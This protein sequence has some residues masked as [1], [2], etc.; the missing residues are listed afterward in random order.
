MRSL[1]AI[2]LR[3]LRR[4]KGRYVLTGL[5]IALG[6]A[7]AFAVLVTSRATNEA[8]DRVTSGFVGD[9]DVVL[10]PPGTFD[11][12]F[13]E[14]T[15]DDV[16]RIPG[17]ADAMGVHA[18]PTAT[19][20]PDADHPDASLTF[21]V[22]GLDLDEARRI[23]DFDLVDGRFFRRER[24][25]VV[26]PETFADAVEIDV[27]A[28]LELSF[29]AGLRPVRV[30]GII[31]DDGAGLNNGGRVAY[32]SLGASRDLAG[33]LDV[34]SSIDVVLEPGVDVD[35]WMEEARR[36]SGDRFLVVKASELASTFRD[37]LAGVQSALG[38]TAVLA[39][40][41]GGFLIFLTFS[42]SVAERTRMY[43]TLRALGSLPAQVSRIVVGEAAAL[44][45][46]GGV[47]G[48]GIGYVLAL[49]SLGFVARLVD[50]PLSGLGFRVGE[51]LIS[52]A[53]GLA[54][55]VG[56]SLVPAR[57]ASSLSPVA[58]MGDEVRVEERVS[59][60]AAR[61]TVFLAG[62]ALVVFGAGLALQAL[63]MLLVLLGAVLLVPV[64]VRP[65]ARGLGAVTARVGRGVGDIAVMHLV[66]ERSRSAYTLALVMVV[67]AATLAIGGLNLSMSETLDEVVD[68]Q[69]GADLRVQAA[70][71]F[72]P[73]VGGELAQIQGVRTASP[74]RF[75]TTEV[76]DG[77]DAR[78]TFVLVIDPTTYF[79]V[80]NFPWVDGD[81]QSARRALARG[82]SV[83]VGDPLARQLGVEV[84]EEVTVRTF[85]G[86]RKLRVAGT[87]AVLG[88]NNG[89]AVSAQDAEALLGAG[90]PMT[91]FIRLAPG[92]GADRA[93]E[94]IQQRLGDR[95][96]LIIE[97]AADVKAFAQSQLSGFFGI[98][99]AIVLVTAI[100]G[101]LGLANTLVV[102]VLAR[103]RE[104]GILRSTGVL[105]RQLWAMVL[106]EAATLVLCAF[107]LSLPLGG[108]LGWVSVRVGAQSLGFTVGYLTPWLLVPVLL[109]I[110]VVVGLLASVGPA[111]RAARL[112]PVAA[113]RFD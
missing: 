112:D 22:N 42:V 10:A 14:A 4:R 38:L 1:T 99:Y 23:H 93:Q 25:E 109:V 20:P 67:L 100:I 79:E 37:F 101:A 12:T 15:L 94:V 62:V 60:L 19:R 26:V 29:Q 66:K 78:E 31:E 65:V 27:G 104:I 95:Y 41:V 6:V 3:S 46:I 63:G 69:F 73:S 28:T 56:A 87:F 36:R 7:V 11:S 44:G 81:E 51:A 61:L 49:A 50:V 17:V 21:L 98:G 113:L 106:A 82:G 111:R 74:V 90:P 88:F 110:A 71:T 91:F 58:A 16:R 55:S 48:L 32:T 105:R 13:P 84:G 80:G 2:S 39:L 85:Q 18:I 34:L 97:S 40:F 30:V 8:L 47:A 70:G 92:I 76:L 45:L 102:S 54:I 64:V 24:A 53:V 72:D 107:V 35:T 96:E 68:S 77:E 86:L 75:G 52:G 108:L 57:R 33:S 43:G 9:A 89:L 103:T 59:L 83:V 5:G